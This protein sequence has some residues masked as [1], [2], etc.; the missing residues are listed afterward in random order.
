MSL[1]IFAGQ[2]GLPVPFRQRLLY[3]IG[4]PI[5]PPT[6]HRGQLDGSN[7]KTRIRKLTEEMFS[8]YCEEL[9]SLFDRHK[10]AYG[11]DGKVLT[12]ITR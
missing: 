8:T 11:W 9:R 10:A 6:L 12:T 2:W 7:E 5:Y 1:V 4:K 3:V